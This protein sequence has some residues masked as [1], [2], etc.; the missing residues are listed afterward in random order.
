MAELAEQL[1]RPMSHIKNKV[2]AP[3]LAGDAK[4]VPLRRPRQSPEDDGRLIAMWNGGVPTS[5][6]ASVVGR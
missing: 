4:L 5:E 3:R 2:H 1:G 6:I